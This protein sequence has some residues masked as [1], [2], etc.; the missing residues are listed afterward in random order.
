M[1]LMACSAGESRGVFAIHSER[2][3]CSFGVSDMEVRRER[4]VEEEL[5]AGSGL[6]QNL[7]NRMRRRFSRME[8]KV[9]WKTA[10]REQGTVCRLCGGGKVR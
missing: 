5:G 8:R 7:R 10:E 4:N 1:A 9:D 3:D 2:K 6:R